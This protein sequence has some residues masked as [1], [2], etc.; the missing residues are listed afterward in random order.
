MGHY[1]PAVIQ[2]IIMVNNITWT[3]KKLQQLS[4]KAEIS[5]YKF[6]VKYCDKQTNIKIDNSLH[7]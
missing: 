1:H 2:I 7:Q 6:K 4:T 5:S 3:M